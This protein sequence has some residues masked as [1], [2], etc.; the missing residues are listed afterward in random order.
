MLITVGC[1][2][3][4]LMVKLL[5]NIYSLVSAAIFMKETVENYDRK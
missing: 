1:G 5:Q 3:A 4:R 2:G